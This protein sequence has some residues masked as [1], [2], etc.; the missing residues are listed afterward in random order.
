MDGD[1][2]VIHVGSFSK[3]LAP[4]LRLAYVIMPRA[5]RRDFITAKRLADLGCPAVD[6]AALAG[7]IN[8]PGLDRHVQRV[9]TNL[10]ERRDA[11]L[12]GLARHTTRQLEVFDS[13]AGM[14][15]V[16]RLRH[17]SPSREEALVARAAGASLGI[18]PLSGHY[19]RSPQYGLLLGYAGVS[20]RQIGAAC[21]VLG[22]CLAGL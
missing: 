11:L 15:V 20:P 12:A 2:R 7:F 22:T 19:A 8:A 5:L 14:H 6:Q 18:Y 16:A 4:S 9:V 21:R 1:D 17:G 13:S 3:V 10:K